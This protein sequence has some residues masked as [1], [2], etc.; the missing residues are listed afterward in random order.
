MRFS[1]LPEITLGVKNLSVLTEL[2]K[3]NVQHNIFKTEKTLL[4]MKRLIQ[5]STFLDISSP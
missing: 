2:F 3:I 4:Q 1:F 5:L